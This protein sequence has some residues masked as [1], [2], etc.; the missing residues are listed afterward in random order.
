MPE[1]IT[2]QIKEEMVKELREFME[3][4]GVDRST[5]IRKLLEKGLNEWKIE[6]AISEYRDGKISLM[7][8]SEIAGVSIWEFLDELEERDISINVSWD[9]IEESLGM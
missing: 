5:A 1:I 3:I 9:T 7:K 4:Y 2:A 6:R 8:A